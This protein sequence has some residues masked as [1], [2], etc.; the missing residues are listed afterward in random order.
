MSKLG[1]SFTCPRILIRHARKAI[2]R[3]VG[4]GRSCAERLWHVPRVSELPPDMLVDVITTAA[5]CGVML[6]IMHRG[7]RA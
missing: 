1:V 5:N 3:D 7:K 4:R 6:Y 2:W